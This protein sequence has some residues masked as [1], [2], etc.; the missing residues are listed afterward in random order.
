M[1]VDDQRS[2]KPQ[3][4]HTGDLQRQLTLRIQ[5]INPARHCAMDRVRQ[6]QLR[7][8]DVRRNPARLVDD[9]DDAFVVQRVG[10]ARD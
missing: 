7:G 3:S 6:G 1:H 8:F 5:A 2:R 10:P 9:L 4:S